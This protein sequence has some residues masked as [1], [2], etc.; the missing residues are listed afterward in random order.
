M[1]GMQRP[2]SPVIRI[3]T[4]YNTLTQS[5]EKV[6]K[7]VKIHLKETVYW[8]VSD[9]AERSGVGETTVIRF[10]RKLGY[11]G[12]Q[13]FKLSVAQSDIDSNKLE[14]KQI[15]ES[16]S[17]EVFAQKVT[18]E[19]ST[20]LRNTLSLFQPKNIETAT[21]K[22]IEADKIYLFGV[23]ASG[24]MAQQAQYRFMRLG[25]NAQYA[26]D[27]HIIAMNSA[28]AKS[29]DVIIGISTSGSTKDLVDAIK[30][31]NENG[32]YIICI[33]SHM[34]SPITKFGHTVLLTYSKENPLDGGA[35]SS[36]ISQTHILDILT[37]YIELQRKEQSLLALQ[38][39][40]KAVSD[41]LY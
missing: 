1:N 39:T 12:Y 25:F 19:N 40:A 24:M 35:F 2:L 27:S 41:K 32:A 21:N 17:I 14:D 33:T 36:L 34:K 23:G 28:L 4:I 10:C 16:D 5:E 38:K 9:L 30:I 13:D 15:E 8:S 26:S 7:V 20:I 29:G 6:A 11:K 18:T 31:G 37:R 22:I 3:N